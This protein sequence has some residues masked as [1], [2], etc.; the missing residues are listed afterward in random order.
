MSEASDFVVYTALVMAV[1]IGLTAW[2]LTASHVK[3][4]K[5]VDGVLGACLVSSAVLFVAAVIPGAQFP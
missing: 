3:V 2:R 1:A 5:Q 4:R